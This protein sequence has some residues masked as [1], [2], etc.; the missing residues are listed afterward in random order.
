MRTGCRNSD[1]FIRIRLALIA[2]T[3]LRI[4]GS[5]IYTAVVDILV[6]HRI[7]NT[8]TV[9]TNA[10][11]FSIIRCFGFDLA[12]DTV[13]AD[14]SA[15]G[16][17]GCGYGQGAGII[18]NLFIAH[19]INQHRAFIRPH[20]GRIQNMSIRL[21]TDIVHGYRTRSAQ[22]GAIINAA[23]HA[24]RR[25]IGKTIGVN[26]DIPPINLTAFYLCRSH[27][28][29]I[30]HRHTGTNSRILSHGY[31]IRRS[32]EF[33]CSFRCHL[34]FRGCRSWLGVLVHIAV[35]QQGRYILVGQANCRSSLYRH[36]PQ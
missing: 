2:Q 14:R 19:G 22:T 18:G 25:D 32:D 17:S 28:I 26:P 9:E 34:R 35:F 7:L 33:I 6:I 29:V 3:C 8:L 5:L 10:T 15:N 12:I 31:H 21:G 4:K 30:G 16:C 23:A 13:H 36:F 24:N 27:G 1:T 11:E 20:L